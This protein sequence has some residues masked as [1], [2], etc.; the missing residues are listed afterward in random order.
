MYSD[1]HCDTLTRIFDRGEAL[2]QNSGQLDFKRLLDGG[3]GIQFFAVWT[4]PQ[5]EDGRAFE[6]CKNVLEYYQSQKTDQTVTILSAA[7]VERAEAPGMLGALLTVE[8]GGAI[9]GSLEKLEELYRRGVRGMTLTWN[10]RNAL[11]RGVGEELEAL[12]G[13]GVAPAEGGGLTAFG[14]AVVRRMEELGM[15]IDVSH[16]TQRG[17]W[18]VAETAAGP[19]IASH[20]NCAALCPHPRNLTDEQIRCIIR[21]GGF[22]GLNLCP[23]FLAGGCCTVDD[24]LAHAMHIL[25]LGGE[26]VLGFG[27]DLDGVER[28]P[29]GLEGAEHMQRLLDA[30]CKKIDDESLLN[31]IFYENLHRIIKK[32]L[33]K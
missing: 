5:Y 16:L 23:D 27:G 9:E 21:H 33:K 15:L 29:A 18:D 11:G 24:V 1:A 25:D 22:I 31:A 14:K 2:Y 8:G 4:D 3:C 32:I 17:F 10:G 7:D 19:F 28:L 6:R 26:Q 30:F 13:G 20:S 12:Y